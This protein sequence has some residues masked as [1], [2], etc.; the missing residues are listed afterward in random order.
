[1]YPWVCKY[2]IFP[3]GHPKVYYKSDIPDNVQ[4]LLKCKVLPPAR[5]FHPL[6][7]SRING[8]LMFTLCRKCA[9]EGCQEDC[10]HTNEERAL[11][12]TWITLEL[13][14]ALTLGYVILEKY[15]AWHFEETTQYLE[16]EG[17]LWA[18]YIDLW[19]KLKQEASGYPSWC[20]NDAEK[21][22]Y[23]EDYE[24][25]E[26]IQ[27]DPEKIEKNEGLRSLSKIMLNSH[28][29]KFGQNPNKSKLSYVSDPAEYVDMMTDDTLEVTDLMYANKEHVAIRWRAKG[30]FLESLPNTNVILAAYTTAQARLKLYTLLEGLQERVCYF[31]TDSVVYVHDDTKWNPPIGDHLGELKDETNGVPLTTWVSA[32]CKNYAYELQ[33]GQ[34]VCKIRGFT[35]NHRSSVQLN[36]DSMKDLVVTPSKR[37]GVIT[38][39]EPHKIVRRD[40]HLFSEPQTKD[41]RMVYNKRRLLKDL[42]TLPFGW[43]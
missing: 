15:S 17:G 20:T 28:W 43:R 38:V 27:L 6:L 10:I 2:G 18:E 9:E 25:H 12:G 21:A 7:P 3:L 32:G 31:D 16:G 11:T 34:Q 5:L 26:G 22:Q 40:G 14:K 29:G 41:Y 36:F 1:M 23:V 33:D 13:E 19:L 30:E 8:K 42:T 24:L 39:Q 35:L 4:G 37:D